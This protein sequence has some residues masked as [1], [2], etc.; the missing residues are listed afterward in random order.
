MIVTDG[1]PLA[2]AKEDSTQE[3]EKEEVEKDVV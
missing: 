1:E 2:H 3:D